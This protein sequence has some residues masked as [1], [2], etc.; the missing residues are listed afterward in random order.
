MIF[1]KEGDGSWERRE[2]TGVGGGRL[3]NTY[4]VSG[5]WIGEG[6]LNIIPDRR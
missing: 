2:S 5:Y 1:L 4:A 3:V 6:F